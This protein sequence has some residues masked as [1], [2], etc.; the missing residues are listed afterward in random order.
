MKARDVGN[1]TQWQLI[2]LRSAY[3]GGQVTLRRDLLYL[4]AGLAGLLAPYD[5]Q[6]KHLAQIYAPP[7]NS[8]HVSFHDGLFVYAIHRTLDPLTLE[9][10]YVDNLYDLVHLRFFHQGRLVCGRRHLPHD[11]SSPR[12]PVWPRSVE[13][14]PL[15]CAHFVVD[16]LG[17]DC[18]VV[19][20]SR[21]H[22]WIF[23]AISAGRWIARR[24][25][26]SKCCRRFPGLPLWITFG[27][28]LLADWP[29][30]WVY[31]GIT[32]VL[33]FLGWTGCA[34]G[35]QQTPAT[36]GKKITPSRPGCSGDDGRI[37]FRGICCR[38]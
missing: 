35:A 15:R 3:L 28:I 6:A 37:I 5:P 32:I 17:G 25:G 11:T 4:V 23:P 18:R 14:G 16:W 34:D 21:D 8:P 26:G 31:F 9:S 24:N 1:L 10:R 27:A 19:P 33:S 38:D 29:P 7:A 36:P 2:W 30:L 20:A 22:W 13:P 12:R